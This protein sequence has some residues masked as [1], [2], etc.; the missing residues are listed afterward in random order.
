MK[1]KSLYNSALNP[2]S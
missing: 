2:F 1:C